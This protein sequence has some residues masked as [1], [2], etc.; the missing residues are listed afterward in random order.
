MRHQQ[1]HT[2][3]DSWRG[4]TFEWRMGGW[5]AL[6]RPPWGGEAAAAAGG[7]EPQVGRRQLQHLA[8]LAPPL[9]SATTC[10]QAPE[11]AGRA[12]SG[13]GLQARVGR[14]CA[15][16]GC[17]LRHPDRPRA[18]KDSEKLKWAVRPP[19]GAGGWPRQ[20]LQANRRDQSHQRASVAQPAALQ[21][22]PRTGVNTPLWG[23]VWGSSEHLC[24]AWRVRGV[25]YGA[26]K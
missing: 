19:W 7:A 15:R 2:G 10:R 24:G 12:G 6:A 26:Q 4:V 11:G 23:R 18:S 17:G 20:R 1:Q 21:A 22:A 8:G 9:Q 25:V 3:L 13:Q 5:A 14:P 16:P